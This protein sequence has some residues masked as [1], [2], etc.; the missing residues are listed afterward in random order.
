MSTFEENFRLLSD[1]PFIIYF[2]LETN[3]GK[4]LYEDFTD[5]SKNIYPVSHCFIVAIN[6]SLH[7]NK[8][9]VLQSFTNSIEELADVSYLTDDMLRHRDPITTWQLLGCG[10]NVVSKK[11]D[12][13]LIEMFCCELK[14]VV[15]ICKK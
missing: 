4:K 15:D 9:T 11:K 14:F 3:C 5:P 8:I 13:S 1:L 10:Q 2:D 6:P 7:L 12:F